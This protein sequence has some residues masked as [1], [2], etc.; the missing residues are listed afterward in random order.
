MAYPGAQ[1]TPF[2]RWLLVHLRDSDRAPTADPR[3]GTGR[4]PD[5]QEDMMATRRPGL[6]P[7]SHASWAGGLTPG[8]SFAAAVWLV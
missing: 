5:Y 4:P 6:P 7:G 3:N 8:S 2:G 1:L